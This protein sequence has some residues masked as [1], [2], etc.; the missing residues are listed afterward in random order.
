ML[1]ALLAQGLHVSNPLIIFIKI[2]WLTF[3][4]LRRLIVQKVFFCI[5][6]IVQFGIPAPNLAA[7]PQGAEFQDSHAESSEYQGRARGRARRGALT[8]QIP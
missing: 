1:G 4:Y 6:G 3:S 8:L 2:I 7:A 5:L